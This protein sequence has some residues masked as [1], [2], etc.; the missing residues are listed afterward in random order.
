MTYH[1]LGDGKGAKTAIP[2]FCGR[3]L[4]RFE[5]DSAQLG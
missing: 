3:D 2:N 1:A 4:L 5:L